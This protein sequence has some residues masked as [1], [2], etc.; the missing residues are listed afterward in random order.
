MGSTRV[1][2]ALVSTIV[3]AF[4]LTVADVALLTSLGYTQQAES[5]AL[6]VAQAGIVH[7]GIQDANGSVS[8]GGDTG[9]NAEGVAVDVAVATG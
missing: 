6:L 8:L 7:A 4:A 3:L 2:L 9:Q 1:R 5:D